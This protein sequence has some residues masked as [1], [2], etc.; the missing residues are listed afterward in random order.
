MTFRNF[1][2]SNTAKIGTLTFVDHFVAKRYLDRF[3]PWLIIFYWWQNNCFFFNVNN[4]RRRPFIILS[5]C[6]S[7]LV[8]SK[9]TRFYR[10]FNKSSEII[11]CTSRRRFYSVIGGLFAF[12]LAFVCAHMVSMHGL[13][14]LVNGFLMSFAIIGPFWFC[15][16]FGIYS[17]FLFFSTSHF[18]SGY[19]NA[20]L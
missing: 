8:V 6:V 1:D 5:I 10:Y 4:L 15:V 13:C 14:I 20:L 12:L 19:V 18:S 2:F 3:F 9:V 11:K 17:P 7:L 16:C